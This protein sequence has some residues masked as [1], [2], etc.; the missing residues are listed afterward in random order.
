MLFI[1]DMDGV[2]YRGTEPIPQ[3]AW[4]VDALRTAG[5]TVRFLTN[6][7]SRTRARYIPKLAD[8]GIACSMDEIVT[9]SHILARLLVERGMT[10]CSAYP[11]GHDG[12]REELVDVAQCR[13]I[14]GDG[15]RADVVAVGIDREF[16]YDKMRIAQ[17]HLLGGARFFSTNRDSTFPVEGGILVPGAGS[18]VAAIATASS[19]EPE[20][21]GK[22]NPLG[23]ALVC[24]LCGIPPEE[25][26]VIGDRLDTDIE[27]GRAAGV[28]TLLV[29]TGVT[30][31][32]EGEAAPSHQRPDMIIPD[33]SQLPEEWIR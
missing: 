14:A 12:L 17:H 11:V 7:S 10:G 6:N 24:R 8:M 33:L 32:E 26:V 22:P 18:I 3:A 25:T 27:A 31:R 9:S 29:L 23:T 28:K 20:N 30:S 21:V 13:L 19:K 16:T 15:P 1:F 2:L 4:G 5:H